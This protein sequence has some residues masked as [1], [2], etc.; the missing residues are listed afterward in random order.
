MKLTR[1]PGDISVK[2]IET[3]GY[4][5]LK[6]KTDIFTPDDLDSPAPALIYVHGCETITTNTKQEEEGGWR[7]TDRILTRSKS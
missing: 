6:F 1:I 5:S 2:T 4:K 7:Q 3:E